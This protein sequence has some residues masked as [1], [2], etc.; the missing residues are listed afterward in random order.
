[1]RVERLQR[2]YQVQ[3]EWSPFELHPETPPEGRERRPRPGPNTAEQA[4]AAVGLV[5]R[6]PPIIANSRL[7]LEASEFAREAGAEAFD[8]LHRAVFRAYFEDGRNIGDPDVL[9]AIARD[10]GLDGDALREALTARRYRDLVD[11]GIQWAADSGLT[12]TPT[13]V[14]DDRLAIVGAQEYDLFESVMERL[15][16]PRRKDAG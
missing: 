14:F 4:A 2:E 1:M 13:F 3:V 10:S 6:S 16:V 9:I 12:S 7:A 15:R 11:E 5:L 8:R